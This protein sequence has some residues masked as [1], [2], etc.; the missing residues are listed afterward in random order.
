MYIRA[1]SRPG[2][3]LRAVRGKTPAL[4]PRPYR[5]RTHL[6]GIVRRRMLFDRERVGARND[7]VARALYL[8]LRAQ[9]PD[10]RTRRPRLSHQQES[11]RGILKNRR[12]PSRTRLKPPALLASNHSSPT[13]C[14]KTSLQSIRVKVWTSLLLKPFYVGS[15]A[16]EIRNL[17]S[18][19]R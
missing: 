15:W 17:C 11:R 18:T 3:F 7:L 14:R 5:A 6:H 12:P 19:V 16:A 10:L 2:T 9:R 4:R 1:L 13:F 8:P